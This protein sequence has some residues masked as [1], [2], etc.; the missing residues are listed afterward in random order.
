MLNGIITPDKI[1]VHNRVKIAKLYKLY[2]KMS[3]SSLI[4]LKPRIYFSWT[5]SKKQLLRIAVSGEILR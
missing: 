3:S 2:F 1:I 5:N 4:R